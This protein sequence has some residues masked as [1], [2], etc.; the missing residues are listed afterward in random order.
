MSSL[1]SFVYGQRPSHQVDHICSRVQSQQDIVYRPA[2]NADYEVNGRQI[3]CLYTEQSQFAALNKFELYDYL[4]AESNPFE[5]VYRELFDFNSNFTAQIF[6]TENIIHIATK[7]TALGSSYNG[8]SDN[9]VYGVMSYLSIASQMSTYFNL[10]YSDI[11]W[12]RI[13]NLTKAIVA[14]PNSLNETSL[15]LRIN[16][17][18]FNTVCL[19]YTSPSPRDKRQSRMPSSA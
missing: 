3:S 9:G 4:I 12:N 14:N 10:T 19:L 18:L 8:V 6:N 11:A 15:S 2:D 5:C 16:A 13:R 7:A 17:E 1:V